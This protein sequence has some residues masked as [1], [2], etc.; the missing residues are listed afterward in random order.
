MQKFKIT[1]MDC[2]SDN[3]EI[4]YDFDYDIDYELGADMEEC[5]VVGIQDNGLTIRC[6]DCG[7]RYNT[8][9]VYDEHI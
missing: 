1:C 2:G 7:N 4:D 6:L 9:D 3:C 5:E 8:F